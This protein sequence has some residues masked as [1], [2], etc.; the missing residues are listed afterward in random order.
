MTLSDGTTL[1]QSGL[2]SDGNKRVLC[3]YQ[4]SSITRV[5]PPDCLMSYLTNDAHWGGG[6][7]PLCRDAVGVFYSLISDCMLWRSVKPEKKDVLGM[8]LNFILI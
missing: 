3:I 5:S 2:G 4:S 8:T 1:G 6:F 7:L